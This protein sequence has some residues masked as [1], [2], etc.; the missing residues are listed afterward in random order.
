MEW[1]S[2]EVTILL[3]DG[4]LEARGLIHGEVA[5]AEHKG[6]WLVLHRQSGLI[7][8]S[9]TAKGT[10]LDLGV[11][12]N[13]YVSQSLKRLPESWTEGLWGRLEEIRAEHARENSLS[14]PASLRSA[15]PTLS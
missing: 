1:K 7:L 3:P 15:P 2:G 9:F 12:L 4:E 6:N 11:Q 5:I 14:L 10:A 8:G 13:N